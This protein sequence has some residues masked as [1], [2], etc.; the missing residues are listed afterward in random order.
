MYHS[1]FI[2]KGIYKNRGS[3]DM[4]AENNV[5]DVH[6]TSYVASLIGQFRTYRV[7]DKFGIDFKGFLSLPKWL[8]DMLLKDAR[9][10][11]SKELDYMDAAENKAKRGEK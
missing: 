4:V 3:W 6:E 2:K 1:L 11:H 10:Q 8:A 5:E 9:I 7:Y